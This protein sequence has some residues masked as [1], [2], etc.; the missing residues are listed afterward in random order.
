MTSAKSEPTGQTDLQTT[1][2]EARVRWRA[3]YQDPDCWV[4]EEKR[5]QMLRARM[6]Y[7]DAAMALISEHQPPAP[8]GKRSAR[9]KDVQAPTSS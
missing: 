9:R 4:N 6:E 1:M 7:Q 3:L 5:T 2:E 8:P